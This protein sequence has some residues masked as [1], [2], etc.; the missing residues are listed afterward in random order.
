MWPDLAEEI[1]YE[2]GQLRREV[3]E[4]T[5]LL[6]EASAGGPS[7][8]R[9]LALAALLHTF[10]TGIENVFSRIAVH[11]D[12]NPPR[13]HAWHRD[14]LDSMA[15]GNASRPA[16]I[17]EALRDR[18]D[19]YLRFRHRFRYSYSI[20]LDW[21]EVSVLGADCEGTLRQLQEEVGVFLRGK[22]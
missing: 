1:H 17:S 21:T 13:G 6:V 7:N 11:V 5:N 18:L 3:A 10:Y 15:E 4:I 8:T 9:T 14:L 12:G 22:T 20:E 16:A 2:L 19:N